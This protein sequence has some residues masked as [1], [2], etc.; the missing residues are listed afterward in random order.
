MLREAF[1]GFRAPVAAEEVGAFI[2]RFTLEG[3]KLF[4]GKTLQVAVGTP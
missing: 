2:A 1:P 4:N 3:A